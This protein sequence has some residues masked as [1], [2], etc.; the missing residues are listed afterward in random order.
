MIAEVH[1]EYNIDKDVEII[2]NQQVNTRWDSIN[3]P[4]EF[5]VHFSI[6]KLLNNGYFDIDF[7]SNLTNF[8]HLNLSV[9][10]IVNGTYVLENLKE[11]LDNFK[12]KF[13][14]LN[15]EYKKLK[16]I[17][18]IFKNNN[19]DAGIFYVDFGDF[20]LIEQNIIV[21][22]NTAKAKIVSEYNFLLFEKA[23]KTSFNYLNVLVNLNELSN[24][25]RTNSVGTIE[26]FYNPN[27]SPNLKIKHRKKSP[28]LLEKAFVEFDHFFNKELNL[29]PTQINSNI[30]NWEFNNNFIQTYNLPFHYNTLTS[31]YNWNF[32]NSIEAKKGILLP[33][34]FSGELQTQLGLEFKDFKLIFSKTFFINK[35]ISAPRTQNKSLFITEIPFDSENTNREILVINLEKFFNLVL[36]RKITNINELLAYSKPEDEY[37]K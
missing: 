25:K 7:A 2:N 1:N 4:K 13:E 22:S 33:R 6:D 19:E 17:V 37:M 30:Y 11:H 16:S 9:S 8:K 23:H 31:D 12:L 28:P 35:N 21:K 18:V 24:Q 15:L 10:L 20:N 29:K 27:L 26:V 3:L 5:F 36:S 32:N 14:D 34:Y